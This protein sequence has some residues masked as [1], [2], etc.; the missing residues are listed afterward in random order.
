MHRSFSMISSSV[1]KSCCLQPAETC[2]QLFDQLLSMSRGE[3]RVPRRVSGSM[4]HLGAA[5]YFFT[6][7]TSHSLWEVRKHG[8][9]SPGSNE[10]IVRE[11]RCSVGSSRSIVRSMKIGNP[12]LNDEDRTILSPWRYAFHLLIGRLRNP[13]V[14]TRS[15]S[16]RS[17]GW[18]LKTDTFHRSARYLIARTSCSI[19]L[20]IGTV[21]AGSVVHVGLTRQ[22]ESFE[23][24]RI[25]SGREC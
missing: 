25:F 24:S 11:N 10:K 23:R 19:R 22:T 13:L 1:I 6:F 5:P 14:S 7:H 8:T 17:R 3:H 4:I 20:R 9:A 2:G 21:P 18:T 15:K 12:L 16:A